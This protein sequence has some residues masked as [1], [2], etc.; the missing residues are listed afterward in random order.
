MFYIKFT[1]INVYTFKYEVF[2]DSKI[3][4]P[5]SHT[6]SQIILNG[7]SVIA[8]LFNKNIQ[9]RQDLLRYKQI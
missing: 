8:L 9:V 5:S 6:S 1:L 7:K 2:R 3:S 4:E